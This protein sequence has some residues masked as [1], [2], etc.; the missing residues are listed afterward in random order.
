MP[1]QNFFASVLDMILA[2]IVIRIQLPPSKHR[3]ATERYLILCTWIS[4]K[5]SPLAGL[6]NLC[7]VQGSMAIG[8]TISARGRSQE[9]DIDAIAALMLNTTANPRQVLDLLYKAIK[10]EKGSRYYD[11][12][13][14]RTRCVT[15]YYDDG[16]HLDIT[17]AVRTTDPVE[18]T[19][20]I[21]HD[22]PEK[23]SE[24]AKVLLMNAWGFCEWFK[25]QT[26]DSTGFA[27]AFAQRSRAFD[28]DYKA[29]VEPVQPHQDTDAKSTDVIALQLIKRFRNV[30]YERRDG[31][32]PPSVMLSC[33]VGHSARP[34]TSIFEALRHH[35]K[36]IRQ[37]LA[38]AQV[39]GQLIVVPNP[40]CED[41][42][43]TDRWPLDLRNQQVFLDDM[44]DLVRQLDR[45]A[46]GNLNVREIEEALTGL[47]GEGPVKPA[48]RA[49]QESTGDATRSGSTV[50]RVGGGVGLAGAGIAGP[51][52]G[53]RPSTN[54]GGEDF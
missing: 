29:S 9:Y 4:R 40:K 8:A 36:A 51:T 48:V 15:I 14:R 54:T 3:T 47:F 7:Y 30:R 28:V 31:R 1:T 41:D 34:M 44:T 12:V 37:L 21:F 17:P 5:D 16:M 2:E 39:R 23:P 53:A 11:M 20:N 49:A 42:K 10:G 35:A 26:R 24:P 46:T 6:V 52:Y 50:H 43:F 18:R 33:L 27:E 38:E 19:S 25:D 32:M 45:L 22:D 13:K